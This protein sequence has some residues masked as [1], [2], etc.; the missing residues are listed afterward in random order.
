MQIKE[1]KMKQKQKKSHD[2]VWFSNK[3]GESMKLKQL[4]DLTDKNVEFIFNLISY[5]SSFDIFF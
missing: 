5:S 1:K 2:E 3:F 4:T